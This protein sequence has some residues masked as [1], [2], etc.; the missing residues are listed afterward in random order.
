MNDVSDEGVP[1]DSRREGDGD[2]GPG[3]GG[4]DCK[5]NGTKR[6]GELFVLPFSFV[7]KLRRLTKVK[8]N[9]VKRRHLFWVQL[10]LGGSFGR[11]KEDWER[12]REGTVSRGKEERREMMM[13]STYRKAREPSTAVFPARS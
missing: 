6:G 1:G 5:I 4:D 3:D 7:P 13:S 11:L 2:G 8:R 9:P 12:R 10:R